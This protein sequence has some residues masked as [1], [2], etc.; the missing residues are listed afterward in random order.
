[1]EDKTAKISWRTYCASN[2]PYNMAAH[3]HSESVGQDQLAR[4]FITQHQLLYSYN[5][6]INQKLE[7]Q[8]LLQL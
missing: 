1:M 4:V 8:W 7:A 6:Q 3:W 5:I 2:D